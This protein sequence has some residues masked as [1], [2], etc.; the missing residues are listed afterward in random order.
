[1]EKI[2]WQKTPMQWLE[3]EAVKLENGNIVI[4]AELFD[5]FKEIEKQHIIK[6]AAGGFFVGQDKTLSLDPAKEFGN[7]YYQECYNQ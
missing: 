2:N 6:A 5:Q 7:N 4:S 1:M 3:S